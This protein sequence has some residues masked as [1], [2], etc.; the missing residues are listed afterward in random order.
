MNKPEAVVRQPVQVK[1]EPKPSFVSAKTVITPPRQPIKA[2]EPVVDKPQPAT[3]EQQP[4]VKE[5]PASVPIAITPIK[6]N[7]LSVIEQEK[8]E[9]PLQK[10]QLN[11]TSLPIMERVQPERQPI[12]NPVR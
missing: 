3:I 4:A 1:E 8:P 11:T 10:A 5:T 12:R 6:A 7:K 2:P 9:A